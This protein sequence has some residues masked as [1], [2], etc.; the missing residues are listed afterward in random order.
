MLRARHYSIAGAIL[1]VSLRACGEHPD[2][3]ITAGARRWW[4]RRR[5]RRGPKVTA[6][7]NTSARAGSERQID[8]GWQDNSPDETG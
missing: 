2:P 1:L 8:V 3:T 6:P 7:S 5:R 4:W